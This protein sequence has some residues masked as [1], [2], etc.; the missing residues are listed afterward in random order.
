MTIEID[1]LSLSHFL[2]FWL[3]A[4]GTLPIR[5]FIDKN[6]PNY[7]ALPVITKFIN[8]RLDPTFALIRTLQN[9]GY[10]IHTPLCTLNRYFKSDNNTKMR[11]FFVDVDD[12]PNW[13]ENLQKLEM[14]P[15]FIVQ[16]YEQFN[17]QGRCHLYWLFE[18]WQRM[19][20]WEWEA[21]QEALAAAVGSKTP[22]ELAHIHHLLRLPYT[23]HLKDNK[24]SMLRILG[25]TFEKYDST[26][27]TQ[28]LEKATDFKERKYKIPA[29]VDKV[30]TT[31]ALSPEQEKSALLSFETYLEDQ[32]PPSSDGVKQALYVVSCKA[33]ERGVPIKMVTNLLVEWACS[34]GRYGETP[35]RFITDELRKTIR[36]AY[37]YSQNQFAAKALPHISFNKEALG[38]LDQGKNGAIKA[39]LSNMQTIIENHPF[40]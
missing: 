37:K 9:K 11:G 18:E 23:Y 35:G 21:Y 30:P 3:E 7:G 16:H 29:K 15:T 26:L 25:G 31:L 20:G 33:K 17:P 24:P 39:T 19:D 40:F 13:Y 12:I 28:Y 34:G 32:T 38:Q 8:P 2:T 22:K 1:Y 27:L 6:H 5:A 36:D 10:G 14:Q 4:D